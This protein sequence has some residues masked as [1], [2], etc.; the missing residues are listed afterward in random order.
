MIPLRFQIKTDQ[1]EPF[2]VRLN[3]ANFNITRDNQDTDRGRFELHKGLASSGS[4]HYQ[5]HQIQLEILNHLEDDLN[6]DVL[7]VLPKTGI[8]H[9]LIRAASSHNTFLITERCDQLCVMCSQPPKDGHTDMFP[10]FE[11]AALLAPIGATI[12]ISGGE[13]TLFKE[14]LFS[15]L[16]KV[17]SSRGDLQFHI[18]SNAQHF[19]MSDIERLRSLDRSRI[20]WG[21]PLYAASRSIHDEIVGKAGAFDKLLQSFS[22]LCVSGVQIELRTVLMRAN[23]DDLCNLSDFIVSNLPFIKSWAIMQLE[24][25]G[26]G[27]MNWS[28]LFFDNSKENEPLTKAIDVARSRGIDTLLFNFPLCTIPAPYR[29]IAPSTISDWKRKYFD[30]CVSCDLKSDCSGFFEWHPNETGYKYIGQT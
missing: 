9:R 25:I 29:H 15:F 6:G 22:L 23:S 17:M 18:L 10:Y 27:R 19:V 8:A 24:N 14:Q 26:Y 4:T 20:V 12:G 7:L 3:H 13:P 1:T 21:I 2:V 11:A 28:K 30:F 16:E 5:N